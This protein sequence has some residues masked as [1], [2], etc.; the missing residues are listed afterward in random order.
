ML[1]VNT[2]EDEGGDG[3]DP[4][5][6][7]FLCQGVVSGLLHHFN[8]LSERQVN[9]SSCSIRTLL[10]NFVNCISN[11]CCLQCKLFKDYAK[12]LQRLTKNI[13]LS[14]DE[15]L[16]TGIMHTHPRLLLVVWV[17]GGSDLQ[18]L[19]VSGA[20]GATRLLAS[21]ALGR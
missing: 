4:R 21:V 8:T 15:F 7:S 16:L 19:P 3:V 17:G 10:Y 14:P 11:E 1:K 12:L 5:R 6:V 2:G 18:R 20:R 9:V 13:Y